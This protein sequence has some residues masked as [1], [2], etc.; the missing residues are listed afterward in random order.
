[1]KAW[2]KKNCCSDVTP[3]WLLKMI[4]S[5]ILPALIMIFR[6]LNMNFAQ[7]ATTAG[8]LLVIIWWTTNLV[9]K[10]PA[11]IFLLLWFCLFSGAPARTIF[12]FPTGETFIMLVITYLFSQAISNCGLIDRVLL[13]LLLR[14]VH[15][16][17]SCILAVIVSFSLTMYVIPQPLARLV[18]VSV[19][20]NSFLK[21]TTVPAAARQV[22]MYAVFVFYAIV[23]IACKD[24]DLIMN[25]VAANSSGAEISNGAWTRAMAV[26]TVGYAAVVIL[27]MLFLGIL[28][29][30]EKRTM[31]DR[32]N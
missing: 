16:P 22:L 29:G 20:F 27:I 6:P 17:V 9:K 21:R 12:T 8:V 3:V 4:L 10:V 7:S 18:L 15:T 31:Q 25:Y 14:F 32:N 1:M 5:L 26:P 11:S 19:V 13:P 28:A 2:L 23:N 30:R 24:A